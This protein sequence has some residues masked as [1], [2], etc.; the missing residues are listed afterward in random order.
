MQFY[1]AILYNLFSYTG[2]WNF[3]KTSDIVAQYIYESHFRYNSAFEPNYILK[4]NISTISKNKS[5]VNSVELKPRY[6][7]YW[8][9]VVICDAL[10]C[11]AIEGVG[12]YYPF[13]MV[14]PG[15]TFSSNQYRYGYQGSEKDNEI[16]G[17]DGSHIT[18]H[19]RQL[20]T[21]I[22]RWWGVDPKASSMPWQSPYVSMDNNPILYNDPLGDWV[23]GEGFFRNVFN[24][25]N[26]IKAQND[27][28]KHGVK[29]EKINGDW[30]V[31]YN[32]GVSKRINGHTFEGSA[33][34]TKVFNKSNNNNELGEAV[35]FIDRGVKKAIDNGLAP[36]DNID[37][38]EGSMPHKACKLVAAPILN[39]HPAIAIPLSL[40]KIVTGKDEFNTK[41][42]KGQRYIAAPLSII[43]TV[44]GVAPGGDLGG[45]IINKTVNEATK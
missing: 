9:N 3:P 28:T 40:R 24:S 31:S 14:M 36:L 17:A 45:Y 34:V 10:S 6:N 41:L 15:R 13:G 18:T 20:D 11:C 42:S 29:A 7:Y 23:E 22:A 33:S 5:E 25:D 43:L 26:K 1:E 4:K 19:F 30:T 27:A 21:R 8:N 32:E 38:G 37:T 2:F 39:A 16:T 35:N 12:D 44:P